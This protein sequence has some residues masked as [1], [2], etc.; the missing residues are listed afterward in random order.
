MSIPVPHRSSAAA[1]QARQAARVTALA[2]GV[3]AV[4]GFVPGLTADL[5][6]IQPAGWGSGAVLLGIL[7]VSVIGNLFHLTMA[8]A[9]LLASGNEDRSRDYLLWGGAGYLVLSCHR[10]LVDHLV[11]GGQVAGQGIGEWLPVA[12]GL[13]MVLI[14][15]A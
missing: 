4:A 12:V 9:G 7:R 3:V 2:F 1:V 14:A 10:L 8:G 15:S 11:A 6:Q 5:G 13:A